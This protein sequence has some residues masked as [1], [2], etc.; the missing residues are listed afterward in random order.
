LLI[1]GCPRPTHVG[2]HFQR[3]A[4]A[5]GLAAEICDTDEAYRGFW[6]RRQIDW[7]LRGHRPSRLSRFSRH[8]V[9][10]AARL[11]PAVVLATGLAPLEAAALEQ[12][13]AMGVTRVNFLTDDPWNRA[14][15]APWF[16]DALRAYDHVFSPRRANIDDLGALGGPRVHYLRFAYDPA[17]HFIE[18]PATPEEVSQFDA[19]VMLAG[20]ADPD[21]LGIVQPIIEAGLRVALYG[22][23]W[24]RTRAT[25]RSA[26][27]HVDAAGLRRATAAAR[28]CLCIVRRANRDGHAMRTFEVPAMGGCMLLEDTRDHRELF[29]ADGAAVVYF[30]SPA[31]AATRARALVADEPRRRQLAA[32]SRQI[33]TQGGHTYAHRLQDMLAAAGRA[34]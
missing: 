13:G 15:R 11:R 12:L 10:T 30:S 34:K 24:D 33:V 22:G 4:T 6:W 14:H 17:T 26:R 23:Y 2:G 8:V 27:G 32:R 16:F 20:G 18:P 21:R 7:R 29:G 28:V 3:A 5:L 31:E 1:V 9:E 19:D 25:A